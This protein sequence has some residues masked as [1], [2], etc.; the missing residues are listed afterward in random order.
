[1]II[2]HRLTSHS[3]DFQTALISDRI[4]GISSESTVSSSTPSD[5][6]PC[7]LGDIFTLLSDTP[8]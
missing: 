7:P 1:M 2:K 4:C 8:T 3:H 5:L 6:I